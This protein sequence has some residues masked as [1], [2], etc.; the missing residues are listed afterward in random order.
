MDE[1][2]F[3]ALMKWRLFGTEDATRWYAQVRGDIGLGMTLG[4]AL[5]GRTSEDL[6]RQL[7]APHP[8]I[9]PGFDLADFRKL[10][11]WTA[12]MS[13]AV[14]AVQRIRGLSPAVLPPAAVFVGTHGFTVWEARCEIVRRAIDYLEKR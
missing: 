9:P 12:Q 14:L 1:E 13:S 4:S 2:E 10:L 7:L 8:E 3:D 11:Q 5:W 6:Q